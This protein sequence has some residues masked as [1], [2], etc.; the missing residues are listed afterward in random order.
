MCEQLKSDLNLSHI[1]VILVAESADTETKIQG[2]NTGA[3]DFITLPV[4]GQELQARVA[5]LIAN[6][7][8]LNESMKHRM[9]IVSTDLGIQSKEEKF[10]QQATKAVLDNISNAQFGV[11]QFAREVGKSNSQLYREL[12]ALT[13]QSPNDFIRNIRLQYAS[14]L[15]RKHAGNVS[16]VASSV[17]FSNLSYFAKCFR[18]KFNVVPSAYIR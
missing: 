2:F 11:N 17:G 8:K 4:H 16:E 14:E 18:Q 12:M 9:Q 10:L 3:D 13:G 6:R 7:K 15:L 1:P 5:S